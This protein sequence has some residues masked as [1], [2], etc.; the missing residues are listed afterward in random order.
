MCRNQSLQMS[1]QD[2][3]M[4]CGEKVARESRQRLLNRDGSFNVERTGLG[5]TSWLNPY[6]FLLTIT[7]RT[8]IGLTVLLYFFTNVF[9]GFLYASIGADALVDTSSTPIENIFL[10][11]FFFSVQTFATIGY[12]T[13]H[14]A[15]F[16]ANLIVTVESYYSLIV[17]ALITGLM[18]ARFAR[19][20]ARI[21]FSEVAVVAPFQDGKGFMVRLVN[22]RNNQLIE[23]SATMMYSRLV[24][25]NGQVK[26]RFDM[27]KLE[28]EKV[29]FLPLALTLVHPIDEDSPMYGLKAEDFE[30]NNAEIAVLISAMDE[31]YA[32]I[33]HQRTSYKP[34]EVKVGYKFA[35][36]YNQVESNE[37]I[38][39]DVRKL[40][41]IEKV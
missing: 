10:R 32:Q 18:F 30:Q 17:T 34:H 14:P 7:W 31:T 2:R 38:S 29:L 39:I 37:Q 20:T 24:E 27:L 25:E 5:L 28:R 33:V 23:V 3:D 11:G 21:M 26:R 19:P 15:G 35:S 12:G 36:I 40:S 9:F 16:I 6:H 8:F 13:I 41:K 22:S 1:E 4:G